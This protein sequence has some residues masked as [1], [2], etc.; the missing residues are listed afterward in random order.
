M[1]LVLWFLPLYP[2]TKLTDTIHF[3]YIQIQILSTPPLPQKNGEKNLVAV[4][5]IHEESRVFEGAGPKEK[6]KCKLEFDSEWYIFGL[7]Q[8][9]SA[10]E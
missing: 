1:Y 6:G 5:P 4:E 9:V 3:H 10:D 2:P 8:K 7:P